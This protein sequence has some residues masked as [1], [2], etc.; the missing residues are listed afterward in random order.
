LVRNDGSSAGGTPVLASDLNDLAIYVKQTLPATVPASGEKPDLPRPVYRAYDLGTE[1]NE[2]YVQL[3]YRLDARDLALYLFDQNNAPIR[4]AKGRLLVLRSGWDVSAQP[5][6]D[7]SELVWMTTLQLSTCFGGASVTLEHDESLKLPG[8]TLEPDTIYDARLNPLLIH[9]DFSDAVLYQLNQ[10]ASG[11]GAVLGRWTVEDQG[12]GSGASNWVIAERGT[13]AVRFV[14]QTSNYFA[15]SLDGRVPDKLGTL[16]WL[17]DR[18]ELGAG[19]QDQPSNWTNYRLSAVLRAEDDDAIGLVFRRSSDARYYRFSL[20][21]E[22]KYR[23]LTRHVD[24]V[25]HVLA[26]DEFVYQENRDYEVVIE[27]IDSVLTVF[28]DGEQIFSVSDGSLSQGT[29]GLYC[30]GQQGALFE[31]I[32]VDDFRSTARSA[33]LY[34]FTTSKFSNFAHEIHSYQDETW[35]TEIDAPTVTLLSAAVPTT[36]APSPSEHRAWDALEAAPALDSVMRTR[37]NELQVTSLVQGGATRALLLRSPEPIDVNRTQLTVSVADTSESPRAVPLSLKLIETSRH[38]SDPNQESVLLMVRDQLDPSSHV[39]EQ[40]RIPPV[41]FLPDAGVSLLDEQFQNQDKGHLYDETFGPNTLDLYE[42]A[43]Q[44]ASE[45]SSWSVSADAILQSSGIFSGPATADNLEKFGTTALR[46]RPDWGDVRIFT[47]VLSN[48][49]GSVGLVFRYRD[50]DNYYRFELNRQFNYRRLVKRVAGVTTLLWEDSTRGYQAGQSLDIEIVAAGARL[51]GFVD[52]VL[53]FVVEDASLEL[54]RVGLYTWANS[55]TRFELLSVVSADRA[56]LLLSPP[57]SLNGLT[58]VDQG[59]S[60]GPSQWQVNS[61]GIVQTA[62]V[63]TTGD[64]SIAL[65][66]T[67]L[68]GG[69]ADWSSV[70]IAVRV[71]SSGGHAV[72]ILFRYTDESNYYRFSMDSVDGYRRLIKQVKNESTVLWEDATS[73]AMGEA[74]DLTLLAQG[75]RLRLWLDGTLL[76][77]LD[78]AAFASGRVGLYTRNEATAVFEGW[79]VLDEITQVGRWEIVD[80]GQVSR[81]SDWRIRAGVMQQRS[82]INDGSSDPALPEKL[83]TMA[84]TGDPD[85][86]DYRIV[87]D[88][89]AEDD[90]ALGVVFRYRDANNYY[91]LSISSQDGYRRLIKKT[92]GVVSVLAETTGGYLVGVDFRLTVE[93]IGQRLRAFFDTTKLFDVSDPDHAQGRVGLYTWA[94]DDVRFDSLRIDRPTLETR[95]LFQDRFAAGDVSDWSVLD[96]GT[97]SAPS[98]WALV[99]GEFRQGSNIGDPGDAAAPEREGT[100]ALAGDPTWNDIALRVRLASGDDGA[101]GVLFRYTDDDNY[102]RF[103]TDR[104]GAYRRL[105]SKEAGVFRVLWQ[106][107]FPYVQNQSYE[108][109]IVAAGDRLEGYLDGVLAFRVT[110]AQHTQGRI[111]L[112]SSANTDAR[113]AKVDVFPSS[114]SSSSY[115]LEDRFLV[116]KSSRWTFEDEGTVNAPSVWDVDGDRLVQTS[117]IR[118]TD[119]TRAQ[120]TNALAGDDTWDDYRLSAAVQSTSGG[121]VGILFRASSAGYYRFALDRDAGALALVKR[122]GSSFSQLFSQP[123]QLDLNVDYVLSVECIGS[124]LTGFVNGVQVFSLDDSSLPNGRVGLYAHGD[125]G[126]RF[127]DVI[128]VRRRWVPFYRFGKED[129]LPAGTRLRVVSGGAGAAVPTDPLEVVRY[130]APQFEHGEIQLPAGPVDL[131]VMSPTGPGHQRRFLSEGAHTG[132]DV[133]LLRRADGTGYAVVPSSGNALQPGEY[134]LR[135]DYRRDGAPQ[136][137]SERGVT[138]HEIAQIDVPLGSST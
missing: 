8:V 131:R 23:R 55:D 63:Q 137:L 46:G 97:V 122:V 45:P 34:R 42:I 7:S 95:A 108:L 37:A 25:V 123:F 110:D 43:D 126:A 81:P 65:R 15:G 82:D 67:T 39:V 116:L 107:P 113:F 94:D 133:K 93:A 138:A 38:A 124:H 90:D 2:N 88:V 84:L 57:D 33:F 85:W 136:T 62:T 86:D 74:H 127:D 14:R 58:A 128:V 19:G 61:T 87:A 68:I 70:R 36:Q 121:A 114:V 76:F 64:T 13:P 40:L 73:Y 16:L 53:Q 75:T 20:D 96:Q 41:L 104:Q 129:V 72:G 115:D 106:D 132:L 111:G 17:H 6:V 79:T 134:R 83:G 18:P 69:Q 56:P 28:Q 9:E 91:R 48:A 80:E 10:A 47:S 35:T 32:R 92:A 125:P 71:T 52:R 29:I 11:S 59:L 60:G 5:S 118:D 100:Y 51:I 101:L 120:G 89:R 103:S 24:G 22:R 77:D 117:A 27:A 3:M 31:D 26:E 50:A 102:Y 12:G 44:G 78:D 98:Q 30:W 1:F 135:F 4:D 105:V 49:D 99:A 54:G 109:L 66:G 130:V 119:A 21:R 112:Y